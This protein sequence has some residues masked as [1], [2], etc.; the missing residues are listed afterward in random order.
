MR[1]LVDAGVPLKDVNVGNMHFSEGKRALSKKVY[2]NDEDMDDLKYLA[3]K[4]LNV[5]IQ[6]VPGDSKITIE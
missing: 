2:V 4:G 1:R 5:Y 6:D 3:G